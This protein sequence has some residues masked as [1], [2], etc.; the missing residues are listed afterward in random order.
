MDASIGNMP[1]LFLYLFMSNWKQVQTSSKHQLDP[2]TPIACLVFRLDRATCPVNHPTIAHCT[3]QNMDASIRKM[4][5]LFLYLFM[6]NCKQTQTSF[7]HQLLHL[8]PLA[9]HVFWPDRSKHGCQHQED[10]MPILIP[11]YEQLKMSPNFFQASARPSNSNHLSCVSTRQSHAPNES[12]NYWS[13]HPPNMDA[14]IR[15][16]PCLFL[17]LFM[18]NYK[19]AQT[20]F[21]HQLLHLAPLARLVFRLDRATHPTNHP[22]IAH[23]TLQTWMPA[24]GRCHAYSYTYLWATENESKLLPSISSTL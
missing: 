10:A 2:L 11:I 12:S 20:S 22:T 5:C 8:A 3:L 9:W 24:S 1:C 14:S 7:S 13:P 16:M 19:Q 21:N 4:P 6:S 23:L 15:K 17:Y 18:S